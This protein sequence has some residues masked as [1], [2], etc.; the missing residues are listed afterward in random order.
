MA[1]PQELHRLRKIP[2]DPPLNIIVHIHTLR[3]NKHI[4]TSKCSSNDVNMQQIRPHNDNHC[5]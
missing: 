2:V 5:Q 1:K 3:S 4:S